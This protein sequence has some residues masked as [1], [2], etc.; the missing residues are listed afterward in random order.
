MDVNN[1]ET[2]YSKNQIE[3]RKWLQDDHSEQQSV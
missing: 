3:W 2:F 1:I